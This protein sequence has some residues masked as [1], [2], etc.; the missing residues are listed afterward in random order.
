MLMIQRGVAE[1][2]RGSVRFHLQHE[3]NF[4]PSTRQRAEQSDGTVAKRLYF[5]YD[6]LRKHYT[7]KQRAL[8]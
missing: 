3:G 4:L 7:S 2:E 6:L 1:G 8:L 5:S